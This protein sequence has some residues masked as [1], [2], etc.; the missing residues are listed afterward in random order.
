[1]I[2]SQMKCCWEPRHPQR[3]ICLW[4][5]SYYVLDVIRTQNSMVSVSSPCKIYAPVFLF[6]FLDLKNSRKH[7]LTSRAWRKKNY[8]N[9]RPVLGIKTSFD[10]IKQFLFCGEYW[11]P[12]LKEEF[13]VPYASFH[14][15][16]V[17]KHT[18]QM[19]TLGYA[20]TCFH[21]EFILF[22]PLLEVPV[23]SLLYCSN[24]I[25]VRAFAWT[26]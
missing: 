15:M 8:L 23:D 18:S 12:L 21:T 7:S 13:R 5:V 14:F 24:F 9:F 3:V 22:F 4:L 1:M 16:G 20:F 2:Q 26:T 17:H 25:K 11:V 19:G 6:T 10:F